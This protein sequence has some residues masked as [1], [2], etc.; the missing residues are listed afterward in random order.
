MCSRSRGEAT[1][2]APFFVIAS[3]AKQ[4]RLGSSAP[5]FRRGIPFGED[6]LGAALE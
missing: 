5:L 1:T 3:K 2:V 4:S 6:V